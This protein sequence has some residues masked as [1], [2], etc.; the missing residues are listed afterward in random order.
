VTVDDPSK[1]FLVVLELRVPRGRNAG[2]AYATRVSVEAREEGTP[3]DGT[4]LRTIPVKQYVR[5]GL[6]AAKRTFSG[7]EPTISQTEAWVESLP[8]SGRPGPPDDVLRMVA[9][10]YRAALADP[11]HRRS[12]TAYVARE[13]DIPRGS[14]G[15]YVRAARDKGFLGEALDRRAGEAE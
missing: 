7:S 10:L 12:P 15:R 3:V 4:V 2:D 9:K 13:G 11:K 5:D 6:L 14:A 8:K 1:D